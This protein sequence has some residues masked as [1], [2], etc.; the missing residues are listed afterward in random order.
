M[1]GAPGPIR[2]NDLGFRKALLYPTELRGRRRNGARSLHERGAVAS[3]SVVRVRAAAVTQLVR[4]ESRAVRAAAVTRPGAVDCAT[5]PAPQRFTRLRRQAERWVRKV[6]GEGGP[7][8]ASHA[9][10]PNRCS[11]SGCV[12]KLWTDCGSR[13]H[14]TS[15]CDARARSD[16]FRCRRGYRG[17]AEKVR[18]RAW[19]ADA[20]CLG[21]ESCECAR[22][23]LTCSH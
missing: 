2:T 21:G 10:R 13:F 15:S 3:T 22:A 17:E 16:P 5:P 7:V 8:R 9:F 1:V 18:V 23:F 19:F 14:R 4:C 12:I 6:M 20:L 11:D